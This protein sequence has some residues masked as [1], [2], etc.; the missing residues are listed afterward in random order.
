MK[1]PVLTPYAVLLVKPTDS[2]EAIRK[3]YWTL[4]RLHHPDLS[5]NGVAQVAWYI[6]KEAYAQIETTTV[7]EKWA[8]RLKLNAGVCR[9]CEGYG[10]TWRRLGKAV[11]KVC[12]VCSGQ[13]RI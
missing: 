6:V 3:T 11:V 7:R 2:D 13:G 1:A 4:A 5:S 12:E 9:K 8:G 10:V